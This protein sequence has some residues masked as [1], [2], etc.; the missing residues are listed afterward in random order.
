MVLP[1]SFGKSFPAV[2]GICSLPEI[3]MKVSLGKISI[4]CIS[5]VDVPG[6]GYVTSHVLFQ[7]DLAMGLRSLEQRFTSLWELHLQS[8]VKETGFIAL[9]RCIYGDSVPKDVSNDGLNKSLFNLNLSR[10]GAQKRDLSKCP[11]I[12]TDRS[13]DEPSP[14]AEARSLGV[15]YH[16]YFQ[17][18]SKL[19]F[20]R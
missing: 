18:K 19:V 10:V 8:A 7:H 11:F 16:C 9:G 20:V 6:P 17:D 4:L 13:V 15:P 2:W 3:S 14:K 12:A 1:A 5:P